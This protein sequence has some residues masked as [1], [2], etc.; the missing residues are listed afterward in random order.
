[1]AT[2]AAIT[3]AGTTFSVSAALPASETSGA[4][5]AV[6]YTAVAEVVDVGSLGKKYSLINH[7]PIGTRATFKFKGSYD[8][9][10]MTLKLAKAISDAGQALMLAASD[11]DNDYTFHIQLPDARDMYF[12]GKVMSFV[13]TIGTVNSIVGAEVEVQ[14][15]G[16]IFE[17]A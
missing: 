10:S 1:M 13:T 9:G 2:S 15:S 12:R 14:I 5:A 11:S 6:S 8:S 7:N 4:Y 3:A 16:D 17:T